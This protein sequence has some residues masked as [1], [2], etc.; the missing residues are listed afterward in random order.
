MWLNPLFWKIWAFIFKNILIKS[1]DNITIHII[2]SEMLRYRDIY[3][4]ICMCVF[5]KIN[6]LPQFKESQYK[7]GKTS[8]CSVAE[9]MYFRPHLLCE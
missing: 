4:H 5:L 8:V 2:S 1:H 7:Y 6:L 9:G 3:A